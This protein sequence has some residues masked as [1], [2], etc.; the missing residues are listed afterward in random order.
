[1]A[2]SL[3]LPAQA[4]AA[5]TFPPDTLR[6]VPLFPPPL[7]YYELE[8]TNLRTLTMKLR[9]VARTIQ[10]LVLSSQRVTTYA[11]DVAEPPSLDLLTS[12]VELVGAAK[13]LFSWLS[14]Y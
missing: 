14:R 12:V 2:R 7:Q 4:G 6:V 13:G 1:M 11:G 5:P 10:A 9:R 8:T 3:Q